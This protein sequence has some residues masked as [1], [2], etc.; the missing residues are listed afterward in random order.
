VEGEG[1]I[2]KRKAKGSLYWNA[3]VTIINL[4]KLQGSKHTHTHTHNEYM[5][6][7]QSLKSEP[8]QQYQLIVILCVDIQHNYHL[9]KLDK[10]NMGSLC[11][12]SN[13]CL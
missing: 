7:K 11:I 6:K 4:I 12:N 10:G 3:S 13:N 1:Y 2:Y 9:E 8:D 5:K